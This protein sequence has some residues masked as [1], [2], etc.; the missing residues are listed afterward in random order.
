[1][2]DTLEQAI[3]ALTL[4]VKMQQVLPLLTSTSKP[5]SGDSQIKLKGNTESPDQHPSNTDFESLMKKEL[6]EA[7]GDQL[8][9]STTRK[10]NYLPLNSDSEVKVETPRPRYRYPLF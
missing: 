3:T 8:T 4:T 2:T 6:I 5:Y 1:M 7:G 9:E 10:K